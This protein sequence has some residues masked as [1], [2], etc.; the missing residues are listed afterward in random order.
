MGDLQ[1][2][3]VLEVPSMATGSGYAGDRVIRSQVVPS[4]STG[5]VDEDPLFRRLQQPSHSCVSR[6]APHGSGS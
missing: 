3:C 6:N 2:P 5:S 1:A 4:H